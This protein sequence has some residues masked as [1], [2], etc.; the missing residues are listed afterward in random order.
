[1][2]FSPQIL[3][4]QQVVLKGAEKKLSLLGVSSRAKLTRTNVNSV[5]DVCNMHYYVKRFKHFKK[6]LKGSHSSFFNQLI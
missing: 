5:K 2:Y 1:M 6:E 4:Y 3:S